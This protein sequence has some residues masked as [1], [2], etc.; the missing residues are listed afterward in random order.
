[1]ARDL[2]VAQE[3]S[4]DRMRLGLKCLT[5]QRAF[6]AFRFANRAMAMQRRTSVRVLGLRR[7]ETPPTDDQI[8]A[9]WRP[10]QVGFILQAL[11]SLVHPSHPDRD[12]ADL[13]WYPTGGGKTEAYLGLAAFTFALR[14]LQVDDDGYDWSAGTAVLMR[15]TL[16]LL[17]IQQFQR[18]LTLVCACELLRL[19][20]V[21]KWGKERFT[22]G[23]WVGL[24]V[25]PNWYASS[26]DALENLRKGRPVYRE[27]PYQIL[28]CP[29]C[30][31]DIFPKHYVPDD[32]RER[33]LIKCPS[34]RLPL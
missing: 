15:Y 30:G 29:W 9:E 13:L 11:T 25:T 26:K 21:S 4:L 24:S 10:F 16:R 6:E 22:I 23:L 28:H 17:T 7:G 18:A 20:D 27:S 31:E 19:E 3:Q 33:T 34:T 12:V 5:E 32:E 8:S 2:I 14:R 1:M